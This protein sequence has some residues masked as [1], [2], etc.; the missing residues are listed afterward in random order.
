VRSE[1]SQLDTASGRTSCSTQ[2]YCATLKRRRLSQS[3]SQLS[4][5]LGT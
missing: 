5:S 4:K 1:M 2:S 3:V